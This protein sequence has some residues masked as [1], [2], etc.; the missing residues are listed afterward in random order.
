MKILFHT[1]AESNRL[2]EKDFLNL[3]GVERIWYFFRLSTQINKFPIKHQ[4]DLSDNLVIEIPQK[5]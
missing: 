4:K 5:P 1:K 2:Q 3:S